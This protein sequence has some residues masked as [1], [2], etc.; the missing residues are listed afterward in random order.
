MTKTIFQ[1]LQD[2]TAE[3]ASLK[4]I[5]KLIEKNTVVSIIQDKSLIDNSPIHREKV[6]T[7]KSPFKSRVESSRIL[8]KSGDVYEISLDVA[9]M[10]CH[11]EVGDSFGIACK[12]QPEVV[13]KILDILSISEGAIIH[14]PSGVEDDVYARD[15]FAS[16]VDLHSFPKKMFFRALAE[17]ATN[18]DERKQLL[19]LSSTAGKTF[20]NR[21][22]SLFIHP[23]DI[24]EHFTSCKPPI[25]FFIEHLQPLMPRYYSISQSPTVTLPN[26]ICF[27]FN[28]TLMD[29][30]FGT[31]KGLCSGWLQELIET[32]SLIPIFPRESSI[33][34][35]LSQSDKSKLLFIAN[36]VGIS[37]FIGFFQEL[38]SRQLQATLIYGHRTRMDGIYQ[39]ELDELIKE[40][41][42][43]LIE[44]LSRIESHPHKYVQDAI[45]EI[46][47]NDLMESKIYVCG[48]YL[49][50][51]CILN[52]IS[53]TAMGKGIH[54]I[55]MKRTSELMTFQDSINFWNEKTSKCDYVKELWS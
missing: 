42:I 32:N 47:T 48:Y 14:R 40:G 20:Y 21:L 9:G 29:S 26:T 13:K 51:L 17:F 18:Q 43:R 12:N 30:F 41:T 5:P 55:F 1:E 23:V 50:I 3:L 49:F 7:I 24:L 28:V 33:K 31:R 8:N 4:G 2:F 39:K 22:H 11:F 10:N 46:T 34:F 16:H 52:S 44:C 38:R 19:F 36:G 53:S 45:A 6:F 54:D 25:S 35:K 15:F 27:A 37:P